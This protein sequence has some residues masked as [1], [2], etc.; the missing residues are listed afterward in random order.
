MVDNVGRQWLTV[1]GDEQGDGAVDTLRN[2]ALVDRERDRCRGTAEQHLAEQVLEITSSVQISETLI[3]DRPTGTEP[4]MAGEENVRSVPGATVPVLVTVRGGLARRRRSQHHWSNQKSDLQIDLTWEANVATGDE[5]AGD[6]QDLR[7]REGN[8]E[9]LRDS[10]SSV[11]Q[12]QDSL[13]TSLYGQDRGCGCQQFGVRHEMGC[14]EVGSNAQIFD[15]SR[16]GSHSG[17]ARENRVEIELTACDRLLAKYRQS[18]LESQMSL[19]HYVP[20]TETDLEGGGV[21]SFVVLNSGELLHRDIGIA[22]TCC[23]KICRLEFLESLSIELCL[24]LFQDMCEF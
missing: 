21:C 20:R 3:G 4:L 18:L 7:R 12:V 14:A 2:H 22:E 19:T 16:N 13:V 8:V 1:G 6:C 5:R 24:Q 11:D 9:R 23:N 17:N 10:A 15:H